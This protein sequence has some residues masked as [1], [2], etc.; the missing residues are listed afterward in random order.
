ML[1]DRVMLEICSA[2]ALGILDANGPMD[3]I[4]L[5]RKMNASVGADHDS[6]YL[7]R[8]LQ[9]PAPGQWFAAEWESVWDGGFL[10]FTLTV[11]LTE[12]ARELIG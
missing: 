7:W 9:Y 5:L 1:D 11:D 8:V 12:E 2:T 6:S 3:G 10:E 4:A